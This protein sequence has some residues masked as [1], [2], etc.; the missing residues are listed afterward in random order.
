MDRNS[1]IFAPTISVGGVR[2]PAKKTT[3]TVPTNKAFD[4]LISKMKNELSPT[5]L[6]NF[7]YKA[8]DNIVNF[9][10][11]RIRSITKNRKHVAFLI[12]GEPSVF[13]HQEAMK[14]LSENK[15]SEEIAGEN[16]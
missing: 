9:N 13:S 7:S 14:N 4:A 6:N 10:T 16:E 3:V 15:L 12:S 2:K 5:I 8:G 11:P 1:K